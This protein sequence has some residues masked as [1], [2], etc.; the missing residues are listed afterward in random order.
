MLPGSNGHAY[1]VAHCRKKNRSAGFYGD[2]AVIQHNKDNGATCFYQAIAEKNNKDDKLDGNVKAPSNGT[3]SG[4]WMTPGEIESN[5]FKCGACHDNGP[6]IRS[7]YLS[8]IKPLD[9]NRPD[10]N[11]PKDNTLPGAGEQTFNGTDEPYYFVGTDFAAWK[12]YQ[13]EVEGNTCNKCHRM[14][15]NNV[16]NV[17]KNGVTLKQ[18][19]A[20]DLGDRATAKDFD[21]LN[22]D[23]A[24]FNKAKNP[25]SVDSPIWTWGMNIG[26]SEDPPSPNEVDF[27]QKYRDAYRAI[28]IC[29]DQFDVNSPLPNSVNCRITQFT[30]F[31]GSPN[32]VSLLGGGLTSDPAVS[33]NASGGLVVFARGINNAIYHT[34]QA[35]MDGAWSPWTSLGGIATGGPAAALSQDGRLNVFVRGTDNA[36]WT[37]G[38]VTPNGEWS[39]WVSIGGGATSD[40][41]VSLNA[42]GGLVVFARGANNA[43]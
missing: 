26:N 5:R 43:L 30:H 1:A 35:Q 9:P 40:P 41:A 18:G 19:T 32:W 23:E 13:V 34:A 16:L 25:H 27:S 31:P 20:R 10:P 38:Q 29:A 8:Q 22:P 39:K 12:A 6:I 33:L 21:P 24:P 42:S 15:V 4:F 11:N 37:R 7:P 36:I 2:I 3:N 14:G 17:N 28:K